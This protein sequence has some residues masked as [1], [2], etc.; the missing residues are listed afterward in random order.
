MTT[1]R[2]P[3]P[4]QGRMEFPAGIPAEALPIL[5]D[6]ALALLLALHDSHESRRRALLARRQERQAELDAGRLPDFLD[7]TA[8]I[9]NADWRVEPVPP[10]LRDRRVEIT[11]PVDRKMI[12]NALNA[13]V[14]C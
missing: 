11:G 9:R 4:A 5:N 14:R 7:E 3:L 12:I 8:V 1:A 10:D 6:S 13:P 2:Q